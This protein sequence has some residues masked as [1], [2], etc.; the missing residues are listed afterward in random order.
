MQG[1]KL[2]DLLIIGLGKVTFVIDCLSCIVVNALK[3]S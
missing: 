1:F 3:I 2:I